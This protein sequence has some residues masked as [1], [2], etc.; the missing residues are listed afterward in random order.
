MCHISYT[1][2]DSTRSWTNFQADF[3]GSGKS[4]YTE[5][6]V[7]V[8]ISATCFQSYRVRLCLL[9]LPLLMI[10]QASNFCHGACYPACFT[11]RG[12]RTYWIIF[13]SWSIEK[14]GEKTLEEDHSGCWSDSGSANKTPTCSFL[15]QPIAG[16]ADRARAFNYVR[17]LHRSLGSL[18]SVNHCFGLVSDTGA[19]W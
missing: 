10:K 14:R 12:I 17:V 19:W 4:E 13:S 7:Y 5:R 9:L 1:T 16:A 6:Y 11:V 8:T 15:L 2:Q 18:R 3:I